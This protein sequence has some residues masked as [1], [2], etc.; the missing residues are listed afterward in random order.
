MLTEKLL[1]QIIYVLE[2]R[3]LL[4][5][6][7]ALTFNLE[8]KDIVK[9]ENTSTNLIVTTKN[10][11]IEL[12]KR[13]LIIKNKI[14]APNYILLNQLTRTKDLAQISTNLNYLPPK[15][16]NIIYNILTTK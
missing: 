2:E 10:K 1:N 8:I 13:N 7:L 9:I 12:E 4:S 11:T 15:I 3:K 6:F 14:S 16:K 5:E